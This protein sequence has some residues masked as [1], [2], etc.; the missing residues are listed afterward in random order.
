MVFLKEKTLIFHNCLVEFGAHLGPPWGT[1]GPPWGHLGTNLGP[2]WGPIGADN[3]QETKNVFF[4]VNNYLPE[5]GSCLS[6][7]NLKHQL[8]WL[9]WGAP[10]WPTWGPLGAQLGATTSRNSK[11]RVVPLTTAV[12]QANGRF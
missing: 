3:K 11:I 1:L 5:A 2:N 10:R 7:A 8:I 12:G 9:I 4:S 6:S